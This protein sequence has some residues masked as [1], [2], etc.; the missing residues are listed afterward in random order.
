MSML[1]T[2]DRVSVPAVTVSFTRYTPSAGKLPSAIV[3]SPVGPNATI[4][5]PAGTPTSSQLNVPPTSVRPP[6]VALPTK[7]MSVDSSPVAGAVIA[8]S[9]AGV[10][11]TVGS[12]T[13]TSTRS[14]V[15]NSPSVADSASK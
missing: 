6:T 2:T 14:S 3:G 9:G 5:T 15:V 7:L 8:T 4:C 13:V 12:A 11:P 10:E 1:C